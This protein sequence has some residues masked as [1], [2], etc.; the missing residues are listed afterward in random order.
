MKRTLYIPFTVCILLFSACSGDLP[1]QQAEESRV[2]QLNFK[3]EGEATLVRTSNALTTENGAAAEIGLCITQGTGYEAY[4]DRTNT[5]Y[6]FK[7]SDT[8]LY[9]GESGS[10]STSTT[11]Y[12]IGENAHI[13]AFIPNSAVTQTNSGNGY[14]IPVTIPAQQTFTTTGGAP[15]CEAIDYLYGSAKNDV[16]DATS[17]TTNAMQASPT[18]IYL[19]HALAKVMFTLQC[20]KDRTPN[21]EY[22]C[23]KSIEISASSGT[24]F[25]VGATGNSNS[26]MQIN[27]GKISGLTNTNTLTLIPGT[28]STP[29]AV[30]AGNSPATV[31]CGLVAPL[32]GK[33]GTVT[34]TITLG[35]KDDTAHNRTY[36]AT[37]DAFNVQWQAGNCYTYKLVLGNTLSIEKSAVEWGKIDSQI[38]VATEEQGIGSA[39]ELW[40]F[41]KKWNEDGNPS[42]NLS[43]YEEY[44]WTEKGVFKIKLTAPIT[45]TG[46]T[47]KDKWTPIGTADNPLTIPFDGQGW[48]INVDLTGLGTGDG[49]TQQKIPTAYAGIIGHTTSDI[50]NVKIM[51]SGSTSA[52][53]EFPEAVYAGILAGKVEGNIT[54]CTAE[55]NGITLLQNNESAA[56][57]L[58]F[59]GLVGSCKGNIINS[60]VYAKGTNEL[61]LSFKKASA[62][63]CVGGLAGTVA[64]TVNNCYTRITELS[65]QDA[66]NAPAAGSLVGY[67]AGSGGTTA[68]TFANSHYIENTA[69]SGSGI[70][71]T[72]CTRRSEPDSGVSTQTDFSGLCTAL[73]E[74]SQTMQSW[75]T[76]T[77]ENAN[78][79]DTKT[80]VSVFLFS[81]R[82]APET[83]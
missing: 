22:D 41:A 74:I 12:L 8:K 42:G 58:Y 67:I 60:A 48:T 29:I 18:N 3:Q 47:D 79:S 17:I 40:A 28:G 5:R 45:I 53:I 66:T 16:G 55:L 64:G 4:P 72:N 15:S 35:K 65:N 49:G 83:K 9:E 10:S 44:G 50:S 78:I 82:G 23:V 75:A 77:E 70:T 24:P 69:S 27:D 32:T 2:L 13:Q 37:S 54:N 68:T 20:D 52:A 81:Y 71:V 36:T 14:T 1:E 26:K 80:V 73:N 39:E 57:G 31:A 63:S 33:P 30:G 25:L 56:S 7:T 51:T 46:T 76:W 11:F 19:H 21:T 59:G 34:L 43:A 38:N 62:G 61:K 6:T